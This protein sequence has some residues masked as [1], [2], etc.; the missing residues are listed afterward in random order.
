V[1]IEPAAYRHVMAGVLF[2]FLRLSDWV[3]LNDQLFAPAAAG[4]I[5]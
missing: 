3:I 1:T 2:L 5:D 4:L